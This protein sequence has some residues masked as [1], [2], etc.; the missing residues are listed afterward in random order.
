[1][2]KWNI[3]LFLKKTPTHF[4]YWWRHSSFIKKGIGMGLHLSSTKEWCL[5]YDL[6]TV[7]AIQVF[8]ITKYQL[9]PMNVN[10]TAM[11]IKVHT[12]LTLH[13][14]IEIGLL[15]AKIAYLKIHSIGLAFSLR[16]VMK[17]IFFMKYYTLIL[18]KGLQRY[19]RSK[20]EVQRNICLLVRFEPMCPAHLYELVGPKN[21]ARYMIGILVKSTLKLTRIHWKLN[22][23]SMA[24]F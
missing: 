23:L 2:L 13:S 8:N 4:V 1:M 20:L 12:Y 18:V 6:S 15:W 10:T 17:K 11:S 16:T 3:T 22:D 5:L 7:K 9:W 24:F 19:Q 14:P 21:Y